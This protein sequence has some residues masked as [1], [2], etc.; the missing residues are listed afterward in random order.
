[1]TNF[2]IIDKRNFITF[3]NNGVI[4]NS[5][6]IFSSSPIY[7]ISGKVKYS[8]DSQNVSYGYVLAFHY[9]YVSKLITVIDSTGINFDGSYILNNLRIDTCRIVAYPNS[10]IKNDFIP[11]YYPSTLLWS[12]AERI[13]P[14]SNLTDVDILTFRDESNVG[15][16]SI[17]GIVYTNLLSNPLFN[18]RVIAKRGNSHIK[19]SYSG[20]QGEYTLMDIP[21]GN[22]KIYFDKI[23]YKNDSIT[24]NLFDNQHLVGINFNM[25]NTASDVENI[26]IPIEY[27]LYQNYPN[28]F[29]P[30]TNIKFDLYKNSNI[31]LSIYDISG[32]L[33]EKLVEYIR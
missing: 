2:N 30:K 10:Q 18:V 1:M 8:N 17:S 24:V 6:N 23:G 11:T 20:E 5:N 27:K 19:F 26:T 32:K 21:S 14:V 22:Y 12:S 15:A 25:N 13:Y 16:S 31:V 3:G 29:N 4:K 33:I 7:S 28:P 9:D